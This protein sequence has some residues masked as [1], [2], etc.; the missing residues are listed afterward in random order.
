M[1]VTAGSGGLFRQAT[2]ASGE[3]LG[4]VNEGVIQFK[5]VP[6]GA[7]TGG[8]RRYQAPERPAPWRGAR[9][10]FGYGPICPQVPTS[11][12]NEY[13]RLIQFDM[14]A[15]EGGISED[16]LHLNLWTCGLRDGRKRPVIVSIHGGAFSIAS[17]NARIYDGAR[18]AQSGDVVVVT[19]SH[20]LASFGYLNLPDLDETSGIPFAANPGLAD[21]VLG[22]QWVRENIE[23]FGGDPERVMIW[24]Q[25]GGGWKVSALLALPAARGLF[26]SAVVQSGSLTRFQER[27]AAAAVAE[28]F[29]AALGLTRHNLEKLRTLP[30][31]ALLEAQ[32]QVGAQ[33]FMPFLDGE[34]ITQHAFDPAAPAESANVPLIV[35]TTRDDAG[36][37]FN[38]F[39]LD[40][41]GLMGLL[42]QQF[43]ERADE[44]RALYRGHVR[45]ASPFLLRARII[46]DAGFRRFAYL[47]AERKAQPGAAPVY[48]YQWNWPSPAYA[49][50]FGA[51]HAIDVAAGFGNARDAILGSGCEPGRSLSHALSGMLIR[52]AST[53]TPG[54]V[55][56]VAW[57]P[58]TSADRNCLVLDEPIALTKD[59]DHEIRA[60]WE[61]QPPPM[62]VLG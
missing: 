1:S 28:G 52:F 9:E 19:L 25:S 20:R 13:G 37:F 32:T 61:R 18:L 35:S 10:C 60:F 38:D 27:D 49:G 29:I 3:I 16:C 47:Q 50:K 48:V 46:T 44:I 54:P 62:S 12:A 30:W 40:E 59:P 45:A 14:V 17:G 36:L 15:A 4:L 8:K 51:V 24:G 56:G 7:P 31:P 53:G 42:R 26:S 33:A 22:L 34:F 58:Y 39:A 55:V 21:L 6:Y 23:N 43:G 41:A 5:G 2:T 57:P 11:I